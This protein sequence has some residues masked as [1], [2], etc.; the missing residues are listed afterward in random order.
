ML[1]HDMRTNEA[2]GHNSNVHECEN[3]C[4]TR[5]RVVCVSSLALHA[6]DMWAVQQA[7]AVPQCL[8][9]QSSIHISP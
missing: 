5:G 8:D 1:Y 4:G 6:D 2:P 3:A 9:K 7:A